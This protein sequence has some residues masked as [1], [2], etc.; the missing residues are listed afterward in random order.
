M[1]DV[2]TESAA[3]VQAVGAVTAVVGAGWVAAREA[4]AAVRREEAMRQEAVDRERR[5]LEAS[6]KAALNLAILAS[7]QIHELRVLLHDETRRGRVTRVSPSRTLITTERMLTAFPIQSLGDADAM[8]AFSYFPGALE[9]ASEVYANLEAAVRSATSG[10]RH[11]LFAAFEM[12]M[13]QLDKAVQRHLHDLKS[14]LGV[15]PDQ[16]SLSLERD[17]QPVT[18]R[19]PVLV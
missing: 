4:R 5:A 10:E 18:H 19:H 17:F 1:T 7:T 15:E 8:V 3:W 13:A 16:R 11:G 12:Q 14:I 2:W 6:R 9:T